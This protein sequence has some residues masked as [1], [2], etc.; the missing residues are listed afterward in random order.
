VATIAK[1]ATEFCFNIHYS[2]WEC[3]MRLK[4]RPHSFKF[5]LTSSIPSITHFRADEASPAVGVKVE[6]EVREA[7]AA[8]D[9]YL[10]RARP[11]K[12]INIIKAQSR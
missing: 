4:V 11:K 10:T 7:E 5:S 9:K 6:E 8:A 12:Y 1:T 2:L 3:W